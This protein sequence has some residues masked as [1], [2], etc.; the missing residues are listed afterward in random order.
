VAPVWIRHLARGSR[1]PAPV[2]QSPAWTK[3]VD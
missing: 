1:A 3:S 2:P